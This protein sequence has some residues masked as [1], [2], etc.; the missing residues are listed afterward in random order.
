MNKFLIILLLL[1]PIGV[2][3]EGVSDVEEHEI[4]LD[5][6]DYCPEEQEE[7][8]ED[9]GKDKTESSWNFSKWFSGDNE[10]SGNE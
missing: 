10:K 7:N 8:L 3:A 2:Y 5:E 4:A 1:A 6:E 9:T